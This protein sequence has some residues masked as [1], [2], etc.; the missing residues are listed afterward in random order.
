MCEITLSNNP[1][2]PD[3][4]G[5][6]VTQGKNKILPWLHLTGSNVATCSPVQNVEVLQKDT[7]LYLGHLFG[8]KGVDLS[9]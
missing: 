2:D 7:L 8:R 9:M 1:I 4:T 6:V 5:C 3:D